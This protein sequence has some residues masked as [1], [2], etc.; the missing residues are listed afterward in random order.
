MTE[1]SAENILAED[2]GNPLFVEV[3]ARYRAKGELN[4]ALSV[5]LRGL[6]A[7]PAMHLGRLL[8]ARVL[9]E[10]KYYPFAAKEVQQLVL[11]LPELQSLKKLLKALSPDTNSESLTVMPDKADDIIAETEI[12]LSVLE[13]LSEN[14]HSGDKNK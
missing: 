4:K 5:C 2:A 1:D 7:N 9:Y 14:E 8:L 11:E 6:S 10:L 3:A 13:E 12:E